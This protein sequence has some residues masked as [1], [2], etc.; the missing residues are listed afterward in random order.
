MHFG[1]GCFHSARRYSGNHFCFLFLQLL[2]CFNSL[3]WLFLPYFIQ[4]AVL[5]VAPFG[6]PR[7]IAR[8]Q[9]PETFRR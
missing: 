5:R 9:L 8:F 1:L 7:I 6:Y 3:R 2:R 4:V